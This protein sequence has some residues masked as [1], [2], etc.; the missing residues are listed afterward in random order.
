MNVSMYG[1]MPAFARSHDLLRVR[2]PEII[3]KPVAPETEE[4]PEQH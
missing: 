4:A 3:G 1:A 2:V